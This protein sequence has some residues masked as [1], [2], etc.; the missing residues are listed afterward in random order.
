MNFY[1]ARVGRQLRNR[2]LLF[3]LTT[4]LGVTGLFAQPLNGTKTINPSG[5][6]YTS[7]TAAISDL[8]SKGVNGPVV[9]QVAAGTY[10][11]QLSIPAIT[12]A[13]ATNTITFDGG[14]GNNNTRVI[15]FQATSTTNAHV[16]ELN[17]AQYIYFRNLTI[18]NT[19]TAAGLGVSVMGN[20]A[21]CSIINCRILVDSTSTSTN[22]KGVQ[23]ANSNLVT[24]ATMCG[25]TSGSIYNIVMDSNE[26]VGGRFGIYATSSYSNTSLEHILFIRHN[27][28]RLAYESGVG[29]SNVRGYEVN[30]NFIDMRTAYTASMGFSHCNGSTSGSQRYE[31]IG[32]TFAHC[33]QYAI[34]YLTP[35]NNGANARIWNNF[36]RGEF[37]NTAAQ[38]F[39]IGYVKNVEVWSNTIVM[40]NNLSTTGY[41]IYAYPTGNPMDMRNNNIVLSGASSNGQAVYAESGNV[42]YS[43]YNNFYKTNSGPGSTL[44]T[45]NGTSLFATNFK[46]AQGFNANSYSENP[47]LASVTDPRPGVICLN[48]EHISALPLDIYNQNRNNPPTIGAAN[49]NGGQT[50]DASAHSLVLPV[51]PIAAG[52][53]DFLVRIQNRGTNNLTEVNVS[54]D[55]GGNVTTVNWTGNLTPCD[56]ISVLFSGSKQITLGTGLNKVKLFTW[57]PNGATDLNIAND[58]LFLNIC[59]P[60]S[61]TYTINP[62]GGAD[63][64]T[65]NQAVEQLNCGGVSGAVT[66]NLV[67]GTHIGYASLVYVP[68]VSASNT[69]TIKGAG[70]GST[71]LQ[72]NGSVAGSSNVI[73]V[74]GTPY[75]TIEDIRL[76][77]SNTSNAVVVQFTGNSDYGTVRNSKLEFTASTTNS[78]TCNFLVGSSPSASNGGGNGN[79]ITLENSQLK[80]G[81]SGIRIH[82]DNA[83]YTHHINIVNNTV[84]GIYYYGIYQYYTYDNVITDNKVSM[85]GYYTAYASYFY[86]ANSQDFSRNTLTNV[87][88]YGI[89]WYYNNYTGQGVGNSKIVNNMI[90]G[91][92]GNY[93][94]DSYGMYLY[95]HS[96]TDVY[97]N[98]ILVDDYAPNTISTSYY[99]S[100][101]AYFDYCNMKVMNNI[102]EYK[103]T[104][105]DAQVIVERNSNLD[106]D[107]NLYYNNLDANRIWSDNTLA[108][109]TATFSYSQWTQADPL[110]NVNSFHQASPFIGTMNLHLPSTYNAPIGDNVGVDMDNDKDL[111]CEFSPTIGADESNYPQSPVIAQ[112]ATPDSVYEGSPARFIN[113]TSGDHAKMGQKWYVDGVLVSSDNNMKYTFP[114]AGTYDVAFVTRNC[115]YT[116]SLVKQVTAIVPTSTPVSDFVAEKHVTDVFGTVKFFDVS[117]FGATAWTWSA[118]PGSNV[119]FSD[120]FTDE[121]EVYFLEPGYYEI[122]LTAENALGVGSDTCKTA[123]ILVR[124]TIGMCQFNNYVTKST[125]G[126]I[127]DDQGGPNGAYGNNRNCNVTIDPCASEV[128]LVFRSVNLNDAGDRLRIYDGS[129]NT[130]NLLASFTGPFGG[131]PG[132]TAGYTALSG[133]MYIDW[134]TDGSGQAAGFVADYTSVSDGTPAPVADFDFPDSIFADQVVEFT[135]TSTGSGLSYLWDFDPPFLQVGMDGGDGESDRYSWSVGATYEVQ[136]SVSNCGG[137]H[138]NK[139]TITVHDPL[140]PPV[141]GF[142]ADKVRIPVQSSAT[143]TDTSLQGPT[144]WKWSVSPNFGVL[145][146]N[147]D[148][149]Q[150]PE[151]QFNYPGQFDVKL[152]VSNSMGADSVV[153]QQ[154]IEVYDYC[155]P[156]VATLTTDVGI[157]RVKL[158]NL[159]N[160]SDIGTSAY[161]SYINTLPGETLYKGGSYDL[162]LER[163]TTTNPMNRKVWIDWNIDGDFADAGELVLHETVSSTLSYT[164]TFRVP[165][166]AETGNSR[167]RIGTSYSNNNNSPCGINPNG[168]FEDYSIVI[169]VDETAPVITLNGPNTV[170]V[171]QWYQYIDAGATASDDID[172]NLAS[173]I[174]VVS[175]VDSSVVGTYQVRYNTTDSAGNKATETVR[176]VIV[177]PD[178]TAP[179]ITLQGA[180][181]DF[182]TVNTSYI[183]PGATAIDYSQRNLTSLILVSGS[184]DSSVLGDYELTYSITD[185]GNNT[186]TVKRTVHVVDDI[187]PVISL[188]GADTVRVNVKDPYVDPGFAVTDNFDQ[189]VKVTVTPPSVNTNVTGTTVLTY[190]ST[191][192]YGNSALVHKRVVIVEDLEAPV[193][194]LN[195]LDTVYV[196]VFSSYNEMG[197]D[198][199]D[200]YCENLVAKADKYPNVNV[201]GDYLITYTITDCEGNT[202]TP[203]TRLVKVVDREAPELNL[204]G[205]SNIVL[206][207]WET[208]NDP[209]VQ[210]DDNYYPVSVLQPMV[211]ITTD[212]SNGINVGE[213]EYCYDLTDPSDNMATR[214]CRTIT[215]VEN[216]T[217][218]EMVDGYQVKVYPNPGA[219]VF[220]VDAGEA[221]SKINSIE[222]FDMKGAKV[223]VVDKNAQTSEGFAFD[224][225]GQTPGVYLVRI[226]TTDR[227][228]TTKIEMIR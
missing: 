17:S 212:Y 38:A 146:V 140:T 112:F 148:N 133:K 186:T 205:L 208:F 4:L 67:S 24:N 226:I 30:Y 121:P 7:F 88:R 86:Y 75:V 27:T 41:G 26:V 94:Y 22:F 142:M 118:N 213:Y 62:A 46:G 165:R 181:N 209:G 138:T 221:N 1:K 49:S 198:V 155:N 141:P 14:A 16:L 28:I 144:G 106:F 12:G 215:V 35:N 227:V 150:K 52:A 44:L 190:S 103:G 116:D 219:G 114:V 110:E 220:H 117:K 195:G 211:V 60:M 84:E 45:L 55:V 191:D 29:I 139:K 154:Y 194:T 21:N 63:F 204:K 159:D 57:A 74:S 70:S 113:T 111:R 147:G 61:G 135:S 178:V 77:N 5:G 71:T 11:G 224:L 132:G 228:I 48:G 129:D 176:T 87:G 156:A 36:V 184:I 203:V 53:Q 202:A 119:V 54:V 166:G 115:Q 95:R 79:Y 207:R 109:R 92:F 34:R 47:M 153:Y 18:Q 172:G 100:T 124:E 104:N 143:F 145:F 200:N 99:G 51:N 13:S 131:V 162:T 164:G 73:T 25:G 33:G 82:G 188:M 175:N 192:I 168:E 59:T 72:N 108:N 23:M 160:S 91:G 43:D 40:Q 149:V 136:L 96:N 37:T 158:G 6:N 93:Q 193:I 201:L 197:T 151:I 80:F 163:K 189:T 120:Q 76:L 107:F 130:G 171:E 8:Q 50:L 218:I 177:T 199:T 101:V 187:A 167:M 157:S 10:T 180:A 90:G 123:Y 65:I 183:D 81:Y 225:S 98:S 126:T 64:L 179:V 206:Q 66:L 69:I 196:N 15:Q 127:L 68:G 216:G 78:T 137:S 9:F 210:I 42:V 152:V 32:N 122:C 128:N 56:T 134:V 223:L 2:L 97:H 185:G 217:G 85:T 125:Q 105:V 222:I 39:A 20:T 89:Y 3:Q 19:G 102:F 31:I 169:K 161:T 214:V 170:Y 174:S 182:L 58:S 83:N 173:F